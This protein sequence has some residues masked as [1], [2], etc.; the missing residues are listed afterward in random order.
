MEWASPWGVG[1]PGWHL[2]CSAMSL[3]F[4][5]DQLDIH[6]GGVDHIDIHHT[7]EIAQSQAATGKKFFNYW[8]HG[9]FLNI[10]GDKKMAKSEENFL[11]LEN[12]FIKKNIYPEIL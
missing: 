10:A 8:L 11:T 1:F 5:R 6:C 4:L 9:A 7:N 2:E 3:K 12:A